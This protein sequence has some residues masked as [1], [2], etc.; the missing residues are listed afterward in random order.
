M[1]Q[2]L[3]IIVLRGGPVRFTTNKQTFED[4]TLVACRICHPQH[5][6][7]VAVFVR[8]SEID[9]ASGAVIFDYIGF[10][11]SDLF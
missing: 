9:R 4:E 3:M 8:T 10:S 1:S 5:G 6:Q 2:K 11:V 7:G